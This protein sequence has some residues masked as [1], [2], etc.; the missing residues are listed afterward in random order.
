MLC[1]GC[2]SKGRA[3]QDRS[4]ISSGRLRNA[5]YVAGCN[6]GRHTQG[7]HLRIRDLD[8]ETPPQIEDAEGVHFVF[9]LPQGDYV[10]YLVEDTMPMIT[11]VE[12]GV[13][14]FR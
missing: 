5:G 4:W 13:K 14:E 8:H 1:P 6:G 9:W 7:G 2:G 3:G 11:V 12:N 10:G